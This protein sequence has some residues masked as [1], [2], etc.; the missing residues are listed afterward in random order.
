MLF[1]SPLHNLIFYTSR[2]D[3]L[4]PGIRNFIHPCLKGLTPPVLVFVQTKDRA[5]ELFKELLYDSIHVDVIHSD[6]SQE[7]RENTVRAF[8]SG[9]IWVLICTEL[10]GR[11]IDFKAGMYIVPYNLIFFPNPIFFEFL[12]QNFLPLHLFFT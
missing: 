6:R 9:G 7:Q 8:R 10:M 12:F 4:P 1:P 2:L 3:K 5:Q 11:G